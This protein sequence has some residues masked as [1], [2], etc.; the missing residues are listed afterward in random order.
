MRVSFYGYR[1]IAEG[2][3]KDRKAGKLEQRLVDLRPLIQEFVRWKSSRYKNHLSYHGE[4]IFLMPLSP[5]VY[6]FVMA[7]DR[8]LVKALQTEDLTVEDIRKRLH[9]KESIGFASYVLID[10]HMI[11]VAAKTYAPRAKAF[12]GMMNQILMHARVPYVFDLQALTHT[13]PRDEVSLLRN[14]RSV[15]MTVD[16]QSNRAE[17]LWAQLSGGDQRVLLEAS[18][19]EVIIKAKRGAD[20]SLAELL[21][22]TLPVLDGDEVT[23]VKARAQMD[24]E[25]AVLDLYIVGAGGIGADLGD[26]D[27]REVAGRMIEEAR[28]NRV[29]QQKLHEFIGGKSGAQ[30]ASAS[31][32]GLD[33]ASVRPR[34]LD[35][36][37]R[38]EKRD[39]SGD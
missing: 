10:K 11:G 2:K 29:L 35:H 8:E 28:T 1:V 39:G 12:L 13:V 6:L 33:W 3:T 37:R 34:L 18:S 9:A 23:K 4:P 38:L 17:A 21:Q 27:E 14:V 15:A 31:A 26:I 16:A 19:F 24:V 5:P 20:H 36:A 25:E 32:L 22:A 30:S 7:R